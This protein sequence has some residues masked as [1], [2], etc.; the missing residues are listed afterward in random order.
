M[1]EFPRDEILRLSDE[2]LCAMFWATFVPEANPEGAGTDEAAVR[3]HQQYSNEV[4]RRG[5]DCEQRLGG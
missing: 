2:E 1:A 4:L 3:D 5:I